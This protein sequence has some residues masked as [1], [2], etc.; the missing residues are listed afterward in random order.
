MKVFFYKITDSH[1]EEHIDSG[2]WNLLRYE[3][4]AHSKGEEW[5]GIRFPE[6]CC[7]LSWILK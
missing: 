5:S 4:A 3:S 2:F 7:G 6:L 1:L